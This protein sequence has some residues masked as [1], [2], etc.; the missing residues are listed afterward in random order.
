M[1]GSVRSLHHAEEAAA[2]PDPTLDLRQ[3]T[4]DDTA[5]DVKRVLGKLE[6]SGQNLKILRILAN[7]QHAFRPFVLLS[8]ALMNQAEL[9]PGEREVVILHLAARLGVSYEWKEHVPMSA[10]AGVT[11]EQ[12]RVLETASLDD[13][14]L[15]TGTQRLAL[16]VADE[17]VEN[18]HL[19]PATWERAK[20]SFGEEGALELLLTIGWWGAFVPTVIQAIGLQDPA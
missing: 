10:V 2:M 3:R 20:E 8:N 18:K 11:D 15:F 1:V 6:G 19:S 12:R 16:E 7:S 13:L 9:P 5:G 14:S 17:V 4:S